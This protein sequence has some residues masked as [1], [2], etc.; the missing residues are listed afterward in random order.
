MFKK[1]KQIFFKPY[2]KAVIVKKRG[3]D[4]VDL[5]INSSDQMTLVILISVIKQIAAKLG[6]DYRALLNKL[7]K[8]DSTIKSAEKKELKKRRYPKSK[9]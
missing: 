5:D 2:I 4:I 1:I 9:K 7:L 6:I 3:V 8:L